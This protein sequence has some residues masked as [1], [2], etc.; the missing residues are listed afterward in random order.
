[1]KYTF[2]MCAIDNVDVYIFLDIPNRTS[3]SLTLNRNYKHPILE[4][5]VVSIL[6]F[7]PVIRIKSNPML[8]V[9]EDNNLVNHLDQLDL[10]VFFHVT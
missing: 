4:K 3:K 2:I 1:M 10:Q 9:M 5:E 8:V 7:S 6:V